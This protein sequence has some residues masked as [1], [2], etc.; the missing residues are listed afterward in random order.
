MQHGGSEQRRNEAKSDSKSE[1]V[2]AAR[3]HI[4]TV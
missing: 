1:V 4:I 2:R 3:V